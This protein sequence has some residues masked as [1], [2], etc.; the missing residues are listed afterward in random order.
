MFD[1]LFERP[2]AVARHRAGPLLE[3]RFAFLT[4]LADRGVSGS[5]LRTSAEKLLVFIQSFGLVT[6]RTESSLATRSRGRL[7]TIGSVR[8]PLD[9][10][11]SSVDWRNI[12]FL[13]SPYAEKIK[14]FAD[15]MEQERGLSPVT[16]RNRCWLVPRIPQSPGL[17]RRFP[18]RDHVRI[19]S[20]R[21][22]RE[23]VNQGDYARVTIRELGRRIAC[24]LPLRGNARLV[25][26][27]TG[28]LHPRPAPLRSGV[29]ADRPILG[30]SAAVTRDDRR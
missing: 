17:R 19:R 5:I 11:V 3:E 10:S 28:R 15:Y 25:P 1:Q 4:K 13:L 30:R 7:P 27:R 23:M 16:I 21:R 18:L 14:A 20:M 24:L 6:D 2:H 29:V 12:L 8:S 9:G 22:S 26:Q